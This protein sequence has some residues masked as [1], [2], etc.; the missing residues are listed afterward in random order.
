MIHSKEFR[1][2]FFGGYPDVGAYRIRPL[3][4]QG[5]LPGTR[6]FMYPANFAGVRR[7]PYAIRPYMYPA[8]LAGIPDAFAA[9]AGAAPG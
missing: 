7:R 6:P 9:P 5:S 1:R 4:G 8:N 2:C 3:P